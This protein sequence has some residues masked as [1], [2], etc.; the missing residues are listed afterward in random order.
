MKWIKNRN[1]YL[2]EAKIKDLILPRQKEEVETIWGKKWL[3]YEEIDPTDKIKQGQWKL[4][5][6]DKDKVLG[7]FFGWNSNPI[8]MEE[9]F[10]IFG[11]LPEHFTNTIMMS[12]DLDLLTDKFKIIM[13]NFNMNKPTVDQ[14]STIFE[15]VFR[16]LSINDTKADNIIKKDEDGRPIK[17]SEGNMIRIQKEKGEPVFDR[18]LVNI[19]VFI[20]SYNKSYKEL[21]NNFQEINDKI[22]NDKNIQ[23]IVSLSKENHNNEYKFDFEIF[24]KDMYLKIVHNPK[25]ILNMSISKFYS[26]CQ[27]LYTGGY[28]TQVLANIFDPNSM[29]AFLYFDSEVFWEDNKISDFLP[30]S[31][32]MI[33]YVESYKEEIFFDRCYPDRVKRV[34]DEIVE[35][36]S[37]NI[38]NLFDVDYKTYIF[39]PDI[40]FE[41]DLDTA[42]HDRFERVERVKM[43][44][45]NAKKIVLNRNNDWSKT[46]I[47]P[48]AKIEEIIIETTD[49]PEN[50]LKINLNPN[51]IKFRYME[52]LTLDKFNNLI[53]DSI[54]FDKCKFDDNILNDVNKNNPNLKKLQIISCD[55]SPNIDFSMFKELK[56]LHLIYTINSLEEFIRITENLKLDKLVISGDLLS[57]KKSKEY[58]NELK[59]KTKGLKIETIGPVI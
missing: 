23:Q 19:N 40:D 2:S 38:Q 54:S 43:I 42:Y 3:E 48:N 58:I 29:P 49:L 8:K 33:R 27:H 6:E 44:G 57:D 25:D 26:S 53:T 13:T 47:S 5:E 32:M 39:S 21:I 17:D 16:K 52:I 22:F 59:K 45:K 35:K 30:I 15:A 37:N 20:D 41:D 34:M 1:Q 4:S 28:R 24:G 18:N 46:K 10:S 56:E 11:N 9:V 51:W 14:M 7:A 12:L 50:L 55:Y 36:Y 31:R